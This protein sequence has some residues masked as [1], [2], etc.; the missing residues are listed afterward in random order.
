MPAGTAGQI[1]GLPE[2]RARVYDVRTETGHEISLRQR[3]MEVIDPDSWCPSGKR[4]NGRWAVR[5][6]RLEV[7]AGGSGRRGGAGQRQTVI[8]QGIPC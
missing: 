6:A 3:Q 2:F 7:T 4:V 8:A 5:R 1:V